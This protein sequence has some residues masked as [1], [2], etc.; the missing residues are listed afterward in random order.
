[1][2]ILCPTL[3]KLGENNCLMSWL[4]SPSF[5]RIGQKN[6]DVLKG[7]ALKMR[8]TILIGINHTLMQFSDNA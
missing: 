3:M 4:F 8:Q 1:M 7:D 2:H 6:A 5:L